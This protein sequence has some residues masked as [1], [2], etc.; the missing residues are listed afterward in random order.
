MVALTLPALISSA[1]AQNA[2]IDEGFRQDLPRFPAI[3]GS[4]YDSASVQTLLAAATDAG[5]S[6]G[7]TG[8]AGNATGAG[9]PARSANPAPA[10]GAGPSS[11]SLTMGPMAE[12]L[13][14]QSPYTQLFNLRGDT[15]GPAWRL[16]P[17]ASIFEYL[18]NQAGQTAAYTTLQGSLALRGDT[19]RLQTALAAEV[20]YSTGYTDND[21]NFYE[22]GSAVANGVVVPDFLFLD[23]T[24]SAYALP[25]IGYGNVN[26]NII[27][28]S[29]TTQTY[30]VSASP[31]A[32]WRMGNLGTSDLGYTYSR[33]WADRNTGPIV[34]SSGVLAPFTGSTVQFAHYD[35]RMPQ[36]IVTRLMTDIS[37]FGSQEE[38]AGFDKFKRATGQIINEYQL[39][40]TFAGILTGGYESLSSGQFAAASGQ[41][42]LWDVGGRWTPNADS[43]ITLLYGSHDL[44]TSIRGEAAY[45]VT[46]LTSVYL[47]YINGISTTQ[48]TLA[49]SGSNAYFGGG[50]ALTSIGY[51][52]NSTIGAL[53]AGGLGA[54]VLGAGLPA[55]SFGGTAGLPL[56]SPGNV[57][58]LQNGIF[59]RKV[60]SGAIDTTLRGERFSLQIYHSEW[61]SLTG[62]IFEPGAFL[63][64]LPQG[65]TIPSMRSTG[66]NLG[67]F[68]VINEKIPVGANLSY[69]V[70]NID[71]A[72]TWAVGA[73]A[74]YR[75][76]DTLNAT[77]RFDSIYRTASGGRGYSLN[78][79]SLGLTKTFE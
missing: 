39:T 56:F 67:W 37:A 53:N 54:S 9:A 38:T 43:T 18:S 60:L 35:F 29:D 26:R 65:S 61:D 24:A 55:G 71:E 25:R 1:K 45:Q 10:P 41:G 42:V 34:T 64:F 11:S 12:G 23:V 76:T 16:V 30:V 72:K 51:L 36:T 58:S 68:H 20:D 59:R 31:D 75:F 2:E 40:D 28:G 79:I 73:F 27:R 69:Q 22:Y 3:R 52:D 48:G 44:R 74:G 78:A 17:Q 13:D 32:K 8:A 77:L 46:P 4:L 5:T 66:A 21:A 14:P 50:G 15:G 70:D 19:P 33:V 6:T 7:G 62:T 49:G 47:S 63:P 57:N